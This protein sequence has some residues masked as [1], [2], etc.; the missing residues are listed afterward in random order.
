MF[1]SVP[2]KV[3]VTADTEGPCR[4]LR[5]SCHHC[6]SPS[7]TASMCTRVR[8]FLCLIVTG[9]RMLSVPVIPWICSIALPSAPFRFNL[10]TLCFLLIL[11]FFIIDMLRL[12]TNNYTTQLI[13]GC[14]EIS[15]ANAI[16][17]KLFKLPSGSLFQTRA[18]SSYI[19]GQNITITVLGHLL[20]FFPSERF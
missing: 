15:S 13:L 10:Y 12:A 19:L 4:S 6:C 2:R 16:N 11:L 14:F 8:L 1:P 18:K 5:H 17:P 20:I 9:Q 7:N 3:L